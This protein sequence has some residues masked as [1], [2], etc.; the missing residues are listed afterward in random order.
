M[1]GVLAAVPYRTGI[2]KIYR[3][4][5][6]WLP[7]QVEYADPQSVD[8][9]EVDVPNAKWY[10]KHTFTCFAC[11]TYTAENCEEIGDALRKGILTFSK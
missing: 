10:E 5:D 1:K 2:P 9:S 4:W 8:Y 7:G 3:I 11:P 6:K